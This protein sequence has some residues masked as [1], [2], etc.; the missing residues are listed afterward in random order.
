MSLDLHLE[1]VDVMLEH[2]P[3]HSTDAIEDVVQLLVENGHDAEEIANATTNVEVKRVLQDYTE[4]VDVDEDSD[5]YEEE[6]D[7]NE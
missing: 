2:I 7:W 3:N 5:D 4:E 1:I 6:Y